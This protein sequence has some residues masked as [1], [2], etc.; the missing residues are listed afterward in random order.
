MYNNVI[1][2]NYKIILSANIKDKNNNAAD[3]RWVKNYNKHYFFRILLFL[4]NG[5]KKIEANSIISSGRS[6]PDIGK[7]T[8]YQW[9]NSSL[10]FHRSAIKNYEYFKSLGKSFYEDVYTSHSFFK[11]GYVLKKIKNAHIIHP[12]TNK[13][14]IIIFKKSLSN[15]YKIVKKFKKNLFFFMLDTIYFLLFFY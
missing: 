1:K 10:C 9:L 12:V 8:N 4:L 5:C 14:D 15:H 13:M 2:N 11:K 7:T 6:I 3:I